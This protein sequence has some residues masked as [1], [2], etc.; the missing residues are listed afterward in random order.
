MKTILMISTLFKQLNKLILR[1]LLL[2]L[3]I[4]P[5]VA[6]ESQAQSISVKASALV[7]ELS[8]L[9]MVTLQE[10]VIDESKAT[11][12]GNI[13]INAQTD[14]DA[15]KMMIKGR[16]G[17]FIRINYEKQLLLENANG[18]G[19][20]MLSYELFGF[21]EDNCLGADPFATNERIVQLNSRGEY[22]LWVG[23]SIDLS[24]AQ[25]GSYSGEFTLEIE[26]ID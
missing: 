26:Y 14:P 9:E 15:G 5:C 13:L 2:L 7:I 25:P 24:L 11:L 3:M 6:L 21:P 1:F 23:G 19:S 18:N 17:E 16:P 10:F 8:E 4:L 20:L 22:F 12:A